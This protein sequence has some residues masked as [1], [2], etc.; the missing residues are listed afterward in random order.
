[1]ESITL[2]FTS[3]KKY[4]AVAGWTNHFLIAMLVVELFS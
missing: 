1:V 4:K 2:A 3:L